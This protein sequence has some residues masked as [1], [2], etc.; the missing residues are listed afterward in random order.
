MPRRAPPCPAVPRRA[1]QGPAVPVPVPVPVP[2][3][4]SPGT[5]S[6]DVRTP[7]YPLAVLPRYRFTP[8][9]PRGN[10]LEPLKDC[11]YAVEA[12]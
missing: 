4:D 12:R 10:P 7:P 11:V 9:A 2:G 1:P 8:T 3:T 5:D 6:P